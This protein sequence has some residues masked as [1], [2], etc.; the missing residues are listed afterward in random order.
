[1]WFV[2]IT[3]N[4][5]VKDKL[6]NFVQET[7][8]HPCLWTRNQ[9]VS[10]LNPKKKVKPNHVHK[11][12]PSK[13]KHIFSNEK[14]KLWIFVAMAILCIIAHLAQKL[15]AVTWCS[16]PVAI[17]LTIPQSFR[18]M[19]QQ[20]G[21]FLLKGWFSVTYHMTLPMNPDIWHV[22]D[23]FLWSIH[24]VI[25]NPSLLINPYHFQVKQTFL[26]H[27]TK[28]GHVSSPRNMSPEK[29]VVGRLLPFEMDP[30]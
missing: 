13:K 29:K 3:T 25:I 15:G 30:F 10:K 23:S 8:R 2:I 1:M 24:Y 5:A 20:N 26:F 17:L 14:K 6:K 7:N 9:D 11:H 28:K 21:R 27:E 19:K 12:R 16:C 4:G 18:W 22:F